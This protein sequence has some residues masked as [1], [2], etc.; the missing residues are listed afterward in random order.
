MIEAVE[1]CSEYAFFPGFMPGA[2]LDMLT[3]VLGEHKHIFSEFSRQ[4]DQDGD[5]ICMGGEPKQVPHFGIQVIF[6]AAMPKEIVLR[7]L[8][9]LADHINQDLTRRSAQ[10]KQV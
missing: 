6:P 5:F 4:A 7:G 2:P 3:E 9:K 10:A 1:H 8:R